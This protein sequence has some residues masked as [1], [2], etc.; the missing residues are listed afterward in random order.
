[1]GDAFGG[2]YPLIDAARGGNSLGLIKTLNAAIA[3]VGPDTKIIRGHGPISDRDNMIEFRDMLQGVHDR[4]SALVVE[5]LTLEQV[6]A[7]KPT[8][9]Y[10][11]QWMGSRGSDGFVTT[12]YNAISER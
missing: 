10:D 1:M 3:I 6:I 2:Q 5:G 11:E 7:A 9:D 12:A 8:A 4:V